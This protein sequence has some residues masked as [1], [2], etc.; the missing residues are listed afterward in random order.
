MWNLRN[1]RNWCNCPFDDCIAC[2]PRDLNNISRSYDEFLKVQLLGHFVFLAFMGFSRP[3]KM[4]PSAHTHRV[5]TCHH[6]HHHSILP[7]PIAPCCS[8]HPPWPLPPSLGSVWT[9]GGWTRLSLWVHPRALPRIPGSQWWSPRVPPAFWSGVAPTTWPPVTLLSTFVCS[10][11][12]AWKARLPSF[13]NESHP[14]DIASTSQAP[15][16]L[17]SGQRSWGSWPWGHPLMPAAPGTIWMMKWQGDV[18]GHYGS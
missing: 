1:A 17:L 15:L 7:V 10:R 14:A 6:P 12:G 3:H 16:G 4:L 8:P 18:L 2:C 11:S 9:A 13:K 5:V